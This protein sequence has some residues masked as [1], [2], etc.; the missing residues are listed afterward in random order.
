ARHVR[1][2]VEEAD[3]VLCVLDGLGPPT[4]ADAAA[5]RMLRQADK[6]VIYL[7][8]R[9]DTQRH[10]EQATELFALG[11]D[12]VPLSALHGR[13]MAELGEALVAALPPPDPNDARLIEPADDVEPE[14]LEG[15]E[16]ETA[17]VSAA[18]LVPRVALLGRPNAGK[19]SLLN[20]LCG[21]E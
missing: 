4:E 3:V 21:E 20:R 19:S 2:A 10:A 5:V 1:A 7:A 13:G 6:P 9:L 12:P 17:P 15:S 16:E 8:N 14:A 18:R 11:I